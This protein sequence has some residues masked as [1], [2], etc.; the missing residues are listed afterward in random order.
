MT[1][2]AARWKPSRGAS[3]C[4]R[5]APSLS[6]GLTTGM[7]IV[8]ASPLKGD[9]HCR[10]M[11][12]CYSA[13]ATY[14]GALKA[15]FDHSQEAL[16]L[17]PHSSHENACETVVCIGSDHRMWFRDGRI[18]RVCLPPLRASQRPVTVIA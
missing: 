1:N 15:S 14:V 8:E 12:P 17:C 16:P 13:Y 4:R 10:C 2:V 9:P 18:R 3:H 6:R 5:D 7:R 11:L